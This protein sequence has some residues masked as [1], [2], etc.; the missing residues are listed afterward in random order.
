[1]PARK[2]YQC[3]VCGRYFPEGQGIVI[4]R[5]G[6]ELAFHSK[7]CLAKFF[8]VFIEHLDEAEFK[9]AARETIKEFEEI[10]K[11]KQTAKII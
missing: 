8:R 6:I 5:A 4:K 3:I 9:K 1:M 2:R 10:L 11:R 7:N